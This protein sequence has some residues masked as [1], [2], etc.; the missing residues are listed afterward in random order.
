MII[1]NI[2]IIFLLQANPTPTD[3]DLHNRFAVAYNDYATQRQRGVLDLAAIRR[4]R[5][6]WLELE[7]SAGWPAAEQS[8]RLDRRKRRFPLGRQAR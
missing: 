4:L 3:A 1:K 8:S 5:A 2:I 6:A 7:K